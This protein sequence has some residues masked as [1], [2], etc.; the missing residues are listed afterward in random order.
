MP[1]EYACEHPGCTR[2]FTS[3]T[4]LRTHI[5]THTGERPF[6]CEC[7]KAFSTLGNL[8]THQLT[9]DNAR[10]FKCPFPNCPSDFRQAMNLKAHLRTHTKERPFR[11]LFNTC[12]K[13]FT[14]L[15]SVRRHIKRNHCVS[16]EKV[17]LGGYVNLSRAK[18]RSTLSSMLKF[19]EF[20]V[21]RA[22][23]FSL[24]PPVHDPATKSQMEFDNICLILSRFKG[25]NNSI[26]KELNDFMRRDLEENP[27]QEDEDDDEGGDDSDAAEEADDDDEGDDDS[28]ER[29]DVDDGDYQQ[30]RR[31]R[32]TS[33]KAST[34]SPATATA[35]ALLKLPS[36]PSTVAISTSS[37]SSTSSSS[38]YEDTRTKQLSSKRHQQ[39]QPPSQPAL[40]Q[41]PL[42]QPPM[43]LPAA[44][45]MPYFFA[46]T[47]MPLFAA[48]P[49][50]PGLYMMHPGQMMALPFGSAVPAQ[51]P[52]SGPLPYPLSFPISMPV[53][54]IATLSSAGDAAPSEQLAFSVLAAMNRQIHSGSNPTPAAAAA[55][56]LP[57]AVAVGPR[58]VADL[59][60]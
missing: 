46:A 25:N 43:W 21:H 18:F 26:A 22:Q 1:K 30:S 17:P 12:G 14:A 49:S 54:G 40:S 38:D 31:A 24:P 60:N 44:A 47:G 41:P 58:K 29:D 6:S 56:S 4:N 36:S 23:R 34:A 52:P 48:A 53:P 13:S 5:R 3:S 10:P 39:S 57:G 50:H 20:E 55:A 8:K 37:T 42:P 28:G 27:D 32:R 7:G 16:G 51:G 11:C 15:S 35:A 45:Q 59:L 2:T 33:N 19:K 9:H